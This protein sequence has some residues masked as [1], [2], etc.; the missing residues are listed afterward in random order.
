MRLKL[1]CCEVFAREIAAIIR[2]SPHAITLKFFSKG[3]HEIGCALMRRNL[4]HE[5]DWTVQRDFDAILLGYGMCGFG[6]T[7]IKARQIPLVIP[8]A[9]D[10]ISILLGSRARHEARVAEH[11]GTYFRS[12]GWLERR[13]NP[14][15]LKGL[16]VAEKNS[17]ND[18]PDELI[19]NYGRDSGEYLAGILCDQTQFYD[20]LAFIETGAEPDSRFER[21]AKTEARN[22]VWKFEKLDGDL[23]LLRQ[24]ISG[25]WNYDHFLIV[26]PGQE[27]RATYDSRLIEAVPSESL[28]PA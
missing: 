26:P 27:I 2:Q 20:R 21:A 10:C 8:R 4:Q 7:G 22:R 14:E 3:L 17:L 13:N 23:S 5:I 24:V 25:Q 9:H 1:L 6:T 19:G 12:S 15:A 28:I 11:P 16:S 18:T